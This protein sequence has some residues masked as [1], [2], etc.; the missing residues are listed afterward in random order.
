M[1]ILVFTNCGK[2]KDVNVFTVNTID[3]E[4][5]DLGKLLEKNKFVFR[6]NIVWK[7]CNEILGPIPSDF[8]LI[9][10]SIDYNLFI[11]LNDTF[12]KDL[13]YY[14]F[15]HTEPSHTDFNKFKKQ[16]YWKSEG[17]HEPGNIIYQPI[18]DAIANAEN[19]TDKEIVEELN[20]HF[21]LSFLNSRIVKNNLL[22]FIR[23]G[24]KPKDLVFNLKKSEE[25]DE[26]LSYF[27]ENAY[28]KD[29]ENSVINWTKLK[30]LLF[31]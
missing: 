27:N 1:K 16:S 14:V 22:E 5:N 9:N 21:N 15:Q 8:I 4:T 2:L 11:E 23:L 17:E 12:Y 13:E 25:I 19:K 6:E 26:V 10:D 28:N 30:D 29:E 3:K 18:A 7:G 20:N 24:K 31:N